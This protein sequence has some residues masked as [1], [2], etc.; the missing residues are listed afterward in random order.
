MS[1]SARFFAS[2]RLSTAFILFALACASAHGQ[3]QTPPSESA[4]EITT[5]AIT[6]QVVNERGEPMPGASVVLRPLATPNAGRATSADSEGRFRVTGLE[7]GLYTVTGFSPAYVFEVQEVD[8]AATYYRLGDAIRVEMIKGGVITGTVTDA[9]GEPVV[10]VRVRALR[11]RDPRG[12]VSRTFQYGS[13][14]RAT[15]D[16]G[17]YRLYGLSPGTYLV[18]AGGGPRNQSFQLNPFEDDAPT[19]APSSTRDGATEYTVRSGEETTADIRYRNDPGHTISGTVKVSGHNGASIVLTSV[20]GGFLPMADARQTPSARGF[21]LT[22]IGD[23]EYHIVATQFPSTPPANATMPLLA[24]SEPKRITV[25]GADVSGI[26]LIPRPL[27]SLSGRIALEP[28]QAPE[29]HR[30]RKP[31][32]A[33]TLIDLQRHDKDADVSSG[34]MRSFFNAIAPDQKG[35][36]AFRNLTPGR[37]RLNSRFYARFWYL[38]SISIGAT[39]RATPAAAKTATPKIDPAANWMTIRSGDQISN[40]TITLAEGA[41]SVRGRVTVAE[42]ESIPSAT[43]VYLVPAEPDKATDVLRYFVGAVTSDGAFTL[44]NLPPGRYWSVLQHSAQTEIATLLK[45]RS[46]E[47]AEA[48]VKLRR[49]AEA[50]K[51]DLEL[52]PCQT[53]ADY[54]LSFK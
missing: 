54:Q 7:S 47:A 29:C 6:G 51:F 48:R 28:S 23:G 43:A 24:R 11:I 39:A 16:R 22:G 42:G 18:S 52:K 41:A 12:Q 32:F 10:G 14:E 35:A 25:R 1:S 44:N 27:A 38:Q 33:E 2:I 36:F 50:Q 5:G 49:T 8:G 9:A 53:L 3:Q 4:N 31:V 15:D 17:V 34:F 19:Y 37:Y 46:P 13:F 26:E 40:V 21:E 20:D 45:L 30:K